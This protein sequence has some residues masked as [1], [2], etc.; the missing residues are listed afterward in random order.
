M[1]LPNE[2]VHFELYKQFCE[3]SVQKSGDY[4]GKSYLYKQAFR[5]VLAM[6]IR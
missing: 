5:P 3:D 6:L 1:Y 4:K 2:Y